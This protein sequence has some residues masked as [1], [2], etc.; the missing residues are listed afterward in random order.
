[1]V[2]RKSLATPSHNFMDVL[3]LF[4]LEQLAKESLSQT[5]YD[6]YRSG[7]WDEVTLSISVKT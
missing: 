7:A 2:Q 4:E 3:N 1:M 6:F 5:A